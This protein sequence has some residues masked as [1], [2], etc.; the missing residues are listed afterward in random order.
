MKYNLIFASLFCLVLSAR[1]Q[2]GGP[3]SSQ[4]S[5]VG[6]AQ[7]SYRA[8]SSNYEVNALDV[9]RVNVYEEP[10]LSME[11]KVSADGFITLPLIN[12]VEVMGRTVSEIQEMLR[13]RFIDEEY[14]IDPQIT[15]F[16][17]QYQPRRVYVH[18]MVRRPGPVG[19]PPEEKM[20]LTQAISAAGGVDRLGNGR[21][22]SIKRIDENGKMIVIEV[23]LNEI[24][25]D[26]QAK[27]IYVRDGDNIQI[28]E[29]MF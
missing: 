10:D 7:S 5:N 17:A 14:L 18:G 23:D 16:V 21:S 28:P 8:A 29:R 3:S 20:T 22:I 15:V 6:F 1:A 25:E 11:V 19:I 27:D 2:S 4:D 13:R 9:L 26:P 24:L 12:K